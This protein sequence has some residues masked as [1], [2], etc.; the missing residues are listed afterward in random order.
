MP[1]SGLLSANI[2]QESRRKRLLLVGL[3]FGYFMVILDTTIVAIALPS[4]RSDLGGGLA[5]LNW[6]V[7]AYTIVFAGLLLTMGSLADL[8]GAKRTF[9]FGLIVFAAASGLSAASQSIGMLIGLRAMLGVGGAAML[10]SALSIISQSFPV[11]AER[12]RAL[13]VWAAVTGV[14]MAAG[15]V[16]G[17]LLVD[18]VGWPS[19][20]LI[21]IPIAIISL[22]IVIPL[23]KETERRTHVRLDAVGQL[24]GILAVTALTFGLIEGEVLGWASPLMIASVVITIG[25]TA[26]FIRHEARTVSPMLPLSLF[27]N[28]KV[29]AGMVAGWAINFGL[30]GMLFIL[31]LFFQQEQGYSALMAGLTFLPLTIPPAIGP[32]LTS[33]IINR[34]GVKIPIVAGFLLAAIGTLLQFQLLNTAPGSGALSAIGLFLFGSGV[35]LSIPSLIVATVAAVPAEQT[36]IASGALNTSRQLGSVIAV[37]LY[38]LIISVSATFTS[39]LQTVLLLTAAVLLGGGLLWLTVRNR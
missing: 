36:G 37:A 2:I 35:C 25:G 32:I 14:A 24:S 27:R 31:T 29:S 11:P 1:H 39:A 23:G 6:I 15:P 22:C 8:R 20:F 26:V 16:L 18:S 3:S 7:N 34:V 5:G 10:P 17:G 33:R 21:N 9:V 13:G 30:M 28:A 12:A 19:I 38:G 4:I